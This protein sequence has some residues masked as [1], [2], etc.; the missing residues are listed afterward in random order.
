MT[1]FHFWDHMI[2]P[3]WTLSWICSIIKVPSVKW[4]IWI[5]TQ[6]HKS[7]KVKLLWT[8]NHSLLHILPDTSTVIHICISP[9]KKYVIPVMVLWL[10]HVHMYFL[11]TLNDLYFSYCYCRHSNLKLTPTLLVYIH[12]LRATALLRKSLLNCFHRS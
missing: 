12:I 4:P 6:G 10:V 2:K 11:F 8:R 9:K 1:H 7:S 3:L 5:F